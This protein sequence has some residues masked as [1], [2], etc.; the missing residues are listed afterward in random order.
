M[1]AIEDCSSPK[2]GNQTLPLA[3]L[4][5]GFVSRNGR[6]RRDGH[7]DFCVRFLGAE[8]LG[9]SVISM[10]AGLIC[11]VDRGEGGRFDVS[12]D[13][14]S[15]VER[16]RARKRRG[17]SCS[18]VRVSFGALARELEATFGFGDGRLARALCEA[19]RQSSVGLCLLLLQPLN[20][21]QDGHAV[22]RYA[23]FLNGYKFNQTAIERHANGLE[24][25]VLNKGS[26][27]LVGR[28]QELHGQRGDGEKVGRLE[29][30]TKQ[31]AGRVV[32]CD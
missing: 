13:R 16:A 25:E 7:G 18:Y 8:R 21:A 31:E 11:L 1:N 29:R 15:G 12:V 5:S 4:G 30:A 9:V 27:A 28:G 10:I 17:E 23:L 2:D 24:H 3:D 26:I 14:N 20:L 19:A 22:G 6:W 32:D